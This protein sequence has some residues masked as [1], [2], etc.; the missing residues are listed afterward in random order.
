MNEKEIVKIVINELVERNLI[1]KTE[2]SYKNTESL[3][4]N[5]YLLQKSINDMKN[6]I[7]DLQKYGLS[8]TTNAVHTVIQNVVKEDEN[9]II[10][11]R[12]NNLK[13]SIHRT[14]SVIKMINLIL[15]D[16]KEDKYYQII[17]LKYFNKKTNEEIAEILE[18]DVSTVSRNRNRLIN[19]IK[20]RFF[21]NTYIDE[22]GY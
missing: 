12:I 7:K 9:I 13:Q 17:E 1:H 14:K 5:Y 4:N 8:K 22:L 18:C 16:I 6:Q 19:T 15:Q 10:E 2:S 11:N 20:I 21:P 3:L